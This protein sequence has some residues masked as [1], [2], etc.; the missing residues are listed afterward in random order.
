MSRDLKDVKDNASVAGSD[1]LSEFDPAEL[2]F[3]QSQHNLTLNNLNASTSSI[4]STGPVISPTPLNASILG[5][6][7]HKRD[8]TVRTQRGDSGSI[9][10]H[11]LHHRESSN[12]LHSQFIST[13]TGPI[14]PLTSSTIPPTSL[15]MNQSIN[16][17]TRPGLHLR[18]F[19]SPT[20][21]EG[22]PTSPVVGPGQGF[23]G[24]DI[25]KSNAK[26]VYKLCYSGSLILACH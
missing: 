20:G 26:S 16:L 1:I 10:G 11:V 19:S 9:T 22:R 12:Q 17:G 13:P 6:S 15:N 23:A 3:T 2:T 14:N 24:D 25:P 21:E 5:A 8:S 4:L 7:V 18:T